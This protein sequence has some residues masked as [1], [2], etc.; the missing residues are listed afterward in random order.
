MGTQN[1]SKTLKDPTEAVVKRAND[2]LGQLE[3]D[4]SIRKFDQAL[5]AQQ[6]APRTRLIYFQQIQRLKR[7]LPKDV[8]TDLDELSPD[9]LLET[10]GKIADKAK[11]AGYTLTAATMKRF[12][13][14]IGRK[15]IAEKIPLPRAR[16]RIP[17]ILTDEELNNLIREAGT[18]TEVLGIG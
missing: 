10:L 4:K 16:S 13:K 17:E 15:D 2:L 12:Y 5:R 1:L 3:N 6:V 9:L 8:T 11:G 18:R 14:L 7:H